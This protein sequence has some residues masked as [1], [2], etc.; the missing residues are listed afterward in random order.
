MDLIADLVEKK[1]QDA[2]ARGEF[3]NLEGEGKPLDLNDDEGVP[4]EHKMAFRILKNSGFI[5]PEIEMRKEIV[6]MQEE[7]ATLLDEQKRD[8]LQK[9]IVLKQAAFDIALEKLYKK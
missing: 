9:Q 4:N 8:T 1:I 6:R 7:L 5:P 2:I 3:K